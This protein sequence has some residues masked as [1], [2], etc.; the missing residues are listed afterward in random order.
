M[1][2]RERRGERA[3]MLELLS[4]DGVVNRIDRGVLE[5]GVSMTL[6]KDAE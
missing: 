1:T 2:G 5:D 3:E 6:R 4:G